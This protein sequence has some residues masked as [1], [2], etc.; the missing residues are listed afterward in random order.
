MRNLAQSQLWPG[1]MRLQSPTPATT[2]G[3]PVQICLRTTA[4]SRQKVRQ[5]PPMSITK[6]LQPPFLQMVQM[7]PT[8][9]HWVYS[10][11]WLHTLMS[12]RTLKCVP[13]AIMRPKQLLWTLLATR[14]V[15]GTHQ[16]QLEPLTPRGRVTATTVIVNLHR[17]VK[18]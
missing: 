4:W 9:M 17:H 16:K 3:R 14:V 10:N 15:K 5:P 11:N 6:W 13:E 12:T 2:N 1:V 8:R 18:M 7:G